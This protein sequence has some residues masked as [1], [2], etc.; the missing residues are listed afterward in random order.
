MERGEGNSCLIL[1]PRGSG[2]SLVVAARLLIYSWLI[3]STVQLVETILSEFAKQA[4]VIRLSGHAQATDRHA[5]R[6]IA[7]R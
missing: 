7:Y 1:G 6:E 3:Y 5:M 4:I 2:K